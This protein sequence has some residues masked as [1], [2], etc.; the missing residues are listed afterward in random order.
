MDENIK[1]YIDGLTID[2]LPWRR[3][4]TAYG[5]AERYSEIFPILERS[6]DLDEWKHAFNVI[7]DFEHQSTMLQPAPFALVFLVRIL[8]KR[9]DGKTKTDELIAQKL[10]DQFRYYAE[11]C[12]DAENMDHAEQLSSFSDILDEEYLLSENW[13]DDELDE[14]FEDPD[15]IPEDLFYSFY[16]YSRAVLSQVPDI[17]DKH[18]RFAKESA[19]IRS[20]L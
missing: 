20:K 12:C 11:V 18:G 19:E 4:V 2:S 7:S 16:Y 17:L 8:E 15:S 14:F 1:N 13:D 5:T 6:D 3:M 10:I 9:L